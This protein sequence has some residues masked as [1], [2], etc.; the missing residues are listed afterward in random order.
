MAW[1]A[2]A[3]LLEEPFDATAY[4]GAARHR[5]G[6]DFELGAQG[7]QDVVCARQLEVR[8]HRLESLP[9]T[10]GSGVRPRCADAL[11]IGGR[12]SRPTQR[13]LR[14]APHR[15]LAGRE[16]A[17]ALRACRCGRRRR[18]EGRSPAYDG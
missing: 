11:Y 15:D 4:H 9:R 13:P 7:P 16:L 14:R 5:H 3:K 2:F 17:Q 10:A 6:V 1:P 12:R 18:G 8:P